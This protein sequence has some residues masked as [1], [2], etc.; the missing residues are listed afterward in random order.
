MRVPAAPGPLRQRYA[1]ADPFL[2]DH[3]CNFKPRH[4]TVG[5]Q[6]F[7]LSSEAH[8][9]AGLLL[10]RQFRYR[11]CYGLR[12][13]GQQRDLDFLLELIAEAA[14]VPRRIARKYFEEARAVLQD[15]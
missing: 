9:E 7:S 13:R 12:Y 1:T 4:L 8:S 14:G 6:S 11:R 5:L 10:K 15:V 3:R 2:T